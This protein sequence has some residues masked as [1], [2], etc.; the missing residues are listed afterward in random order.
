MPRKRLSTGG[1]NLPQFELQNAWVK[2]IA[3]TL[4]TSCIR[5]LLHLCV[6]DNNLQD[7]IGNVQARCVLVGIHLLG[8]LVLVRHD[9]VVFLGYAKYETHDSSFAYVLQS[10]SK[11][12]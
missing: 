11:H 1:G 4:F 2:P 6:T 7:T 3:S 10:K 9:I 12:Q 8:E 5:A